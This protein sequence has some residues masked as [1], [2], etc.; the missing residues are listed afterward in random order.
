MRLPCEI[1]LPRTTNWVAKACSDE[2]KQKPKSI[3]EIDC[4]CEF[5]LNLIGFEK[6]NSI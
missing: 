3:T 6:K 5:V 1:E 4:R 2:I